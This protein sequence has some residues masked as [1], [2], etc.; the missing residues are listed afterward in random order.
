[1]PVRAGEEFLSPALAPLLIAVILLACVLVRQ[2]R[3]PRR[4]W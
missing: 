4:P 3:G 1:M 2:L